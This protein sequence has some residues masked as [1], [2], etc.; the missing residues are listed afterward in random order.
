MSAASPDASPAPSAGADDHRVLTPATELLSP[1]AAAAIVLDGV[2]PV[3][4]VYDVPLA[5]AR[6]RVAAGDITATVPLPRFDNA[7]VDGYGLHAADLGSGAATLRVIGRAAAGHA[8]EVAAAPGAAVRVLTGARVPEGVA[9]V[10][11]QERTVRTGDRL[12][13]PQP[14]EPGANIRR[15][16]EDVAPGTVILRAG[17][18]LDARHL[19][20]LAAAG[21]GRL[22]VRRRLRVGVLS[23]GDELVEPG[24]EPGPNGIVDSNRPMLTALIAGP[25]FEVVDLGAVA[26]RVEAVAGVLTG[27]ARHLDLVVSSGGVA[28]SEADAVADAIR[29]AGGTCRSLKLALRP[30][31][32]IA[33]GRLGETAVLALAGNPVAAMVGLLLF[34]RPLVARLAGAAA[35]SRGGFPAEAAEP[36]RHRPG[37]T[38]FL[39]AAIVGRTGDGRPRIV[40]LGRGGSAR[41]LPL[42]AADGLAELAADD[43]DAEVGATVRFHPFATAFAL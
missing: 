31:K 38:E 41:L 3:D 18:V 33:V 30:G 2:A 19:A 6:G 1:E 42:A 8:A 10:I 43:G 17:T 32:P 5:A 13:V 7:A 9:A 25:A 40:S 27:A 20:I 4:G 39:P 22:T 28:G 16:G 35:P 14:P 26:D 21:I 11:A 37:R 12:T 23:T 29:Q 24:V 36:I 34:G 15:R